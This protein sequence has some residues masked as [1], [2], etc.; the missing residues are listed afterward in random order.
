[1]AVS[2][3]IFLTSFGH[4]KASASEANSTAARPITVTTAKRGMRTSPLE[5]EAQQ[6][7]A[8]HG[9]GRSAGCER[10]RDQLRGGAREAGPPRVAICARRIGGAGIAAQTAGR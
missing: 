10:A 5:L 6:S 4:W 7:A 1:M 9:R 2:S 8:D 3:S